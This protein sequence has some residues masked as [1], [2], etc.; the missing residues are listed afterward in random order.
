[1]AQ[2]PLGDSAKARP[3]WLCEEPTSDRKQGQTSVSQGTDEK[4]SELTLRQNL[5]DDM[6]RLRGM[7]GP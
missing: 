4:A 6:P 5:L 7:Q 2:S 1:M 3:L